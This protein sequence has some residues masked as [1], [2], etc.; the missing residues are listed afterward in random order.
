MGASEENALCHYDTI[1]GKSQSP[2][3]KNSRPREQTARVQIGDNCGCGVTAAAGRLRGNCGCGCGVILRA[4]RT[5]GS[6]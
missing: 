2:A 4:R 6:G 3:R 1:L 5:R